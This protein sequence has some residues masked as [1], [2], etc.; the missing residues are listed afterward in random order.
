MVGKVWL[1]CASKT[2]LASP[3]PTSA[4]KKN[5][6]A[7]K[8]YQTEDC[9]KLLLNLYT[10]V[11]YLMNC[12][13]PAVHYYVSDQCYIDVKIVSQ[14][15]AWFR[16]L[17]KM[18]RFYWSKSTLC[19]FGVCVSIALLL[20][21]FLFSLSP[22][23]SSPISPFHPFSLIHSLQLVFVPLTLP[24]MTTTQIERPPPTLVSYPINI[25]TL[26]DVILDSPAFRSNVDQVA[27]QADLFE[28]W[29]EGF[30]RVLKQYIDSLSSKW[31]TKVHDPQKKTNGLPF[32]IETNTQTSQLCKQLV[33][34][35]KDYAFICSK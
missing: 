2:F 4:R 3:L 9:F 29:L 12:N 8:P 35:S 1:W 33:P 5:G 19:L 16:W 21:H 15:V 13:E 23:P 34:N 28:K 32:A 24:L 26:Q 20:F 6:W 31:D 11:L 18:E 7:V 14:V 17:E 27:E 22:P 30:V 10:N 25:L